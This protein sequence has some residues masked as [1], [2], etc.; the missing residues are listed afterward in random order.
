MDMLSRK[1]KTF[2]FLIEK[3]DRRRTLQDDTNESE[4]RKDVTKD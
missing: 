1:S 4:Q 3:D 2:S